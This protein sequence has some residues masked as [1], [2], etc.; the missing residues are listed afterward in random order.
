MKISLKRIGVLLCTLLLTGCAEQTPK[1]VF[2]IT[3]N[4]L[5]EESLVIEG[6]KEEYTI[7]FLTDTHLIVMS[8]DDE[9]CVATNASERYPMFF[10]AQGVSSAEQFPVWMD[11]AVEKQL[12][13]VLF[14][15]DIIDYPSEANL[16]YLQSNLEQLNMPYLYTLGNHD[17]T[18]LWEY[19]TD[20][21]REEYLPLMK[22]FVGENTAIQSLDMGEFI[23]V[24]VDNSEGQINEEA[25]EEYH[26]ILSQ[27][28]PVI[29]M[30]HVPLLTQSVLTKAKE[31]WST[32]VV[33]GGGNY[34][35]IYPNDATETFM[36]E[37]TAEDSPVVAILSGHVHFYDK[38][39]VVG[40]KS[41]VQIVGDGGFKGKGILLHISGNEE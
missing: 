41:I 38:D 20:F 3:E 14:G 4:V 34:G 40:E 2:T 12:D 26:A 18:Y 5:T 7:L 32:P 6:L 31:N 10:D 37:T 24:S 36:K 21:G 27:G 29:V 22:P 39:F 8:E 30:L 25:L 13:A 15:G 17:W 19:M 9:E 16:K 23:I 28:K 33:I 1:S 35:G 11:Y